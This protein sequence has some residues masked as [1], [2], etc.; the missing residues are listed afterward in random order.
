M[1]N[2][3][4]SKYTYI[5]TNSVCNTDKASFCKELHPITSG[6]K[7]NLALLLEHD[8][9]PCSRELGQLCRGIDGSVALDLV[10]A[11]SEPSLPSTVRVLQP[12]GTG[13]LILDG[14]VESL[15]SQAGKAVLDVTAYDTLITA[16]RVLC[17]KAKAPSLFFGSSKLYFKYYVFDLNA[18]DDI[19]WYFWVLPFREP[20][21]LRIRTLIDAC[22]YNFTFFA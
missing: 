5:P 18:V 19:A 1:S 6:T 21:S 22:V 7:L 8:R 16:D 14:M 11:R 9:S 17:V 12:A 20:F 10:I 4:A 2:S 15:E 3:S 13:G